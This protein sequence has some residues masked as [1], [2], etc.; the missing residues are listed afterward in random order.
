MLI[1]EIKEMS[2]YS[3]EELQAMARVV[4]FNPNIDRAKELVWQLCT[5]TG[6]LPAEVADRITKLAR[7]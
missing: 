7:V 2:N 3:R 6:L 5:R 1:I 4:M